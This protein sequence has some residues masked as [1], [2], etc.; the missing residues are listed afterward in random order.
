LDGECRSFAKEGKTR[1]IV[2]YSKER[3]KKDAYNRE[4]GIKRIERQV[5]S[6]KLTKANL[7]QRGYNKF[8]KM[9]GKISIEMDY[10][11][12]NEDAKWEMV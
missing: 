8:L 3:A 2:G 5:K 10:K 4:R 11:K 9:S 1:L 12:V 7:N 6:G